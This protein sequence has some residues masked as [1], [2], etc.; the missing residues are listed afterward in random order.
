MSEPLAE[1]LKRFT[2]ESAV[3]DRDALLFQAGRASARPARGWK[4]LAAALAACQLAT[5]AMFWLR[6]VPTTGPAVVEPVRYP[7]EQNSPTPS[8]DPSEWLARA[9]QAS[10]SSV[11]DLPPAA[12]SG[13]LVPD[14][15]S[16]RVSDFS[17]A[18]LT[19]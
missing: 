18:S 17:N 9:R 1:R 2:P 8:L 16:L 11:A 15:P 12:A 14:V 6:P 13:P 3:I 5:L 4:M 7:V 19:D 10:G